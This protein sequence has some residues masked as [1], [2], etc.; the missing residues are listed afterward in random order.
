MTDKYQIVDL[1]GGL[2]QVLRGETLVSSG[3]SPREANLLLEK[4]Q[5][6]EE[7]QSFL[8]EKRLD[9][10]ILKDR[11]IEDSQVLRDA[12]ADTR[13]H[14]LDAL[15]ARLDRVLGILTAP[16][17]N[18]GVF[19]LTST[20]EDRIRVRKYD[21]EVEPKIRH[22]STFNQG[23]QVLGFWASLKLRVVRAWTLIRSF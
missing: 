8:K 3:I 15:I 9:F 16:D 2:C 23:H 12:Y 4:L 14:D 17:V 7:V 19:S 6:L 22:L 13:G 10:A 18:T 11:K 5:T 20:E 21:I 1:K